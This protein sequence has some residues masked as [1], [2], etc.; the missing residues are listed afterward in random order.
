M[1]IHYI[2][3]I[4]KKLKKSMKK[5]IEIKKILMKMIN[6]KK[7]LKIIEKNDILY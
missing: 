3:E 7:R 5:N 1:I 2:K 6:L 4:Q